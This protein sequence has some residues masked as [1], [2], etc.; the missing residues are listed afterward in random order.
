[1][2]TKPISF[3]IPKEV[4]ATMKSIGEGCHTEGLYRLLAVAAKMA[5]SSSPMPISNIFLDTLTAKDIVIF[6]A[7]YSQAMLEEGT[8]YF[9][10]ASGTKYEESGR[11]TYL[12]LDE[13]EIIY[14][15]YIF[16]KSV[17]S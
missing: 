4:L 12:M 7:R 11:T 3:R 6:W 10:N 1:M 17:K 16:C 15:G 14:Q 5:M 9:R 13:N 2:R 8:Y